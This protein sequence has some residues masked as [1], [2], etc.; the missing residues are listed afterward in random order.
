MEV[1]PAFSLSGYAQP[2]LRAVLR[3]LPNEAW[4]RLEDSGGVP[5][6]T[7]SNCRGAAPASEDQ[8]ANS[9]LERSPTHLRMSLAH[10]P[11]DT[12]VRGD[13]RRRDAGCVK[14]TGDFKVQKAFGF[15]IEIVLCV[16][17][18]MKVLGRISF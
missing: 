4:A 1:L 3:A 2:S 17:K 12:A 15:C 8:S 11:P 18:G 5:S 9:P 16:F 6:T 7:Y 14:K 10:T 13:T